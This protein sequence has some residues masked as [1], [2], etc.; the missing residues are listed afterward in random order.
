M[1]SALEE[2]KKKIGGGGSKES[3]A[4]ESITVNIPG[5]TKKSEDETPA[6]GKSLTYKQVTGGTGEMSRRF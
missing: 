6:C 1:S 5:L 3:A 2:L 4:P